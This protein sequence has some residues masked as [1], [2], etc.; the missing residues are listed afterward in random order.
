MAKNLEYKFKT[1]HIKIKRHWIKKIYQQRMI[2]LLYM[3]TRKNLV[4]GFMKL[5]EP[6]KF[7]AFRNSF[8][9]ELPTE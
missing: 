6:E 4:N 3:T 1:K 8:V 5:L 9:G 7:Y 2:E